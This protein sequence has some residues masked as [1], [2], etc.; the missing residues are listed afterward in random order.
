MASFRFK[1]IGVDGKVQTGEMSAPSVEAAEQ[2]ITR[3][4]MTVLSIVPLIEARAAAE[5]RASKPSAG[6]LSKELFPKK[7][8][9]EEAAGV[10][11][12][13]AVMAEAGVP[14]VEALGAV[15]QS[16]GSS[17]MHEA[18]QR[19]ESAIVQGRSL[20]EAL[21]EA[22]NIYS[23]LVCDMVSVAE[24]GGKLSQALSNAASYMERSTE[25]RKKVA[26]AMI[27]PAV[28]TCVSGLMILFLMVVILPNFAKT[29]AGMNAKLPL[30]TK[31]L[32]DAGTFLRSKPLMS[33]GIAAAMFVGLR[34]LLKQPPI[35]RIVLAGLARVPLLG[36]LML[37]LSVARA[38]QTLSALLSGNVPLIDALAHAGRVAGDSRVQKACEHA[39]ETVAQGGTLTRSFSET[40]ILPAS[41][42]QLAA[43]G[44]RTGRLHQL[45]G[46]AAVQMEQEADARLKALT[47]VFEPL[48][49][50]GMGMIVG[51]ITISVISPLYSLME[52]VK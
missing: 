19:V 29:F 26:N 46:R 37:K 50:L 12:S 47:T 35:K 43:V 1:A 24:E 38:V 10:L 45:L 28:L 2:N 48:L 13:L 44:E 52:Q 21:R 41:M 16:G 30:L 27:Y 4:Q 7:V 34:L 42:I 15:M 40:R 8:K 51:L 23:T 11:R 20:S 36:D 32:L 22:G 33:L 49:V 5:K 18:L 9:I 17:R 6:G 39:A 3:Q 31:V 14:L 25:L